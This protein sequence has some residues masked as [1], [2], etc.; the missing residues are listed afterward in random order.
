MRDCAMPAPDLV[1]PKYV[2]LKNDSRFD[3]RWLQDRLIEN[4]ELLGLGEVTVRDKERR[5]SSGG[6][7][8]LLLENVET[9]T[10]YEV[11]IQ[12]GATD[13]SHIIR[14]IEYWDVERRRYPQYKHVAVIVAEDVT[15]RFLN[16]ISLLNG[17]I[18][19]M[20]IQL[21]GV[22][23]S[24][25]F[26]LVATRVLDLVTLGTEEEDAGETVGRSYWESQASKA[27]MQILDGFVEMIQETHQGA[28][29]KY[30]KTYIGL[31]LG[32]AVKNFVTFIPRKSPRVLTEF[33]IPQK[34]DTTA[35]LEESGLDAIS[36]NSTFGTY[37]GTVRKSDLA[38]R[39]DVLRQLIQEAYE[40]HSRT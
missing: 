7:L 2:S 31:T 5:Q 21:K 1:P 37:R 26:T 33:S 39:G 20:A 18:P 3:E 30:N 15:S 34:D 22:E 40:A 8:D 38:E 4:P 6:R 11:E 14:T 24:G 10:R 19:L 27:S 12:L 35:K 25:E 28:E 9:I 16:V 29:P 13:E 32:G 17:T 23:V 36:Y